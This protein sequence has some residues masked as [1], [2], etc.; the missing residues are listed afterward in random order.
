[1]S[2]APRADHAAPVE[3]DA[4]A[5]RP[6]WVR[7]LEKTTLVL[8]V[9]SAVACVLMVLQIIVDVAGRTFFDQPL[10]GTLD[11]T[12]D[13]WM[14]ATV[15]LALAYAQ[16]RNEHI[17]ATMVTELMPD[18][19]QRYAEIAT[20]VLVGLL[21]LGMAYFGWTAALDSHAIRESSNNVR[22]IPLWPFR[23]L[24]PLGCL[25]LTVQC[26]AS[27]YGIATGSARESHA[28]ELV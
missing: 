19:W 3:G 21:G 7:L 2:T 4:Q 25:G 5:E 24:V 16:M 11:M 9:P 13:W 14:V 27:I 8:L 6:R 22:S 23:F 1:M 26:V 17:R 12:S 28:G 10:K 15:F 18:V 20:V